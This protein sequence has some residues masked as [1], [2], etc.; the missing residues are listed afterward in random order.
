MTFNASLEI[1]GGTFDLQN[2]CG[3][4]ECATEAW[5]SLRHA[6]PHVDDV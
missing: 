6:C 1:N 5:K 2:Q 3:V 4:S